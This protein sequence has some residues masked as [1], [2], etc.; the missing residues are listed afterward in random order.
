M[1]GCN[2]PQHHSSGGGGAW[3]PLVAAVIVAALFAPVIG[4][5][6][7]VLSLVLTFTGMAAVAAG[8]GWVW[9]RVSHR[10]PRQLQTQYAPQMQAQPQRRGFQAPQQPAVGQGG[11]H[12]HIHLGDMSPME[13]AETIR[14]IRGGR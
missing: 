11:Q 2:F 12:L 1:T 3:W 13:R 5:F 4:A 6:I 7:H 9:W 8:G 14:Q 10:Q